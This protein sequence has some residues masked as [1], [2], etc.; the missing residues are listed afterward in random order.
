M[1]AG[2]ITRADN[3]E[4]LVQLNDE[5]A[6]YVVGSITSVIQTSV[7]CKCAAYIRSVVARLVGAYRASLGGVALPRSRSAEAVTL[8]CGGLTLARDPVIL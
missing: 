3:W 8:P 4:P 6:R 2:W 5:S 1:T 7:A